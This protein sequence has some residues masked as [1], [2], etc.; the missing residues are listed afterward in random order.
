MNAVLRLPTFLGLLLLTLQGASCTRPPSPI[1]KWTLDVDALEKLPEIQSLKGDKRRQAL[2]LARKM[3]G[4][5]L[6]SLSDDGRF[7]QVLGGRAVSEPAGS[8]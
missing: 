5:V 6:V 8:V 1:G 2:L 4:D 3:M 7:E